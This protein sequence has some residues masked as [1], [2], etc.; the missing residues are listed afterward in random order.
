MV[1]DDEAGDHGLTEA[2]TRLDQALV[3]AGDGVFG[4][5]DASDDRA[6]QRLHDDADARPGEQAD[7]LA[8]GDRRV[9]VRGPPDIAYRTGNVGGRMD[10][11]HSEVLAG[12]ARRRAVF[13]DGGRADGE[14]GR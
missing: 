14:R 7:T 6:Q 9:R 13:V 5:H 11:E 3:G 10:V 12:K 2:P 4:E 8:V 1:G